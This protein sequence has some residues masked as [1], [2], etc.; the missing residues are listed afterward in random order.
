MSAVECI[1][2]FLVEKKLYKNKNNAFTCMNTTWNN[3][4]IAREYMLIKH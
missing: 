4:I 2:H 3:W 1:G